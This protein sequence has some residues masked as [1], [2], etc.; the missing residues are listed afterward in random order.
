MIDIKWKKLHPEA[1]MPTF[2]SDGA[3]AA[4]VRSVEDVTIPPGATIMVKLGF[5]LEIPEGYEI[6]VRPRSGLAAKYGITILNSPGTIDSDY[7]GENCVILTN[8]NSASFTVEVG[9]R[10]AQFALRQVPLCRFV[11]EDELSETKRGASGFGS[12][13]HR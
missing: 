5:A 12:T 7:R 13:G 2:E 6:Q 4:D 8:L 10:I 1:Q 3:A 9:D 11:Q